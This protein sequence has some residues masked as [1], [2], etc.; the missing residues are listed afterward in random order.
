MPTHPSVLVIWDDSHAERS[1][2][3]RAFW[4][5]APNGTV[6]SPA[7]GYCSPGGSHR[8]IRETVREIRRQFPNQVVYRNGKIWKSTRRRILFQ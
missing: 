3:F 2:Y 5:D 6:G 1:G 7:I 8:T 4:S